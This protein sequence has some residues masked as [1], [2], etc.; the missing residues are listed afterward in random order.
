MII[1]RLKRPLRDVI[2]QAKAM[3]ERRFITIEES[4]VPELETI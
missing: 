1:R 4:K 2:E 3:V